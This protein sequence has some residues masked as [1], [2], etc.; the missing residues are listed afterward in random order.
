MQS[1]NFL[2]DPWISTEVVL[3]TNHKQNSIRSVIIWR[4]QQIGCSFG[5]SAAFSERWLLWVLS[6]VRGGPL[7]RLS[8]LD[9]LRISFAFSRRFTQL[10]HCIGEL[11]YINT[12]RA[13]SV[14]DSSA[15]QHLRF[16]VA[17]CPLNTPWKCRELPGNYP[18]TRTWAGA[19]TNINIWS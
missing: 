15:H 12:K 7:T 6:F 8:Q 5:S 2:W 4:F 16:D 11:T 9:F 13:S 17:S 14:T 10:L 18:I 3:C 1:I 19:Y